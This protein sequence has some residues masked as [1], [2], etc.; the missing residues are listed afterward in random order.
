MIDIEIVGFFNP[1]MACISTIEIPHGL[2]MLKQK[3]A[4][5]GRKNR[6]KKINFSIMFP[7]I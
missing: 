1:L 6:Y 2:L 4:I 7:L 3:I 5:I